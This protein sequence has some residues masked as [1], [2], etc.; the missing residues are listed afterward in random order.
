MRRVVSVSLEPVDTRC[1]GMTVLALRIKGTAFLW[2]QVCAKGDSVA[3]ISFLHNTW[4]LCSGKGHGGMLVI[5]GLR[6]YAAPGALGD[7]VWHELLRHKRMAQPTATMAG[8]MEL[9]HVTRNP[10]MHCF[11]LP[12]E[13]LLL[14]FAVCVC[15]RCAA[16]LRCC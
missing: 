11:K 10:C 5:Q 8:W 12:A 6:L 7:S 1:A 9:K 2:H 16:L 3:D 15:R 13:Q 4:T 14:L